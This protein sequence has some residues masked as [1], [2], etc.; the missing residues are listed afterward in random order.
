MRCTHGRCPHEVT[1]SE[2]SA[3]ALVPVLTWQQKHKQQSKTL[4][5]VQTFSPECLGTRLALLTLAHARV[6]CSWYVR[7]RARAC[8]CP[9]AC[10][11]VCV[12]ARALYLSS[13]PLTKCCLYH[14]LATS[15]FHKVAFSFPGSPPARDVD[16]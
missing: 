2:T 1:V 8:S 12:C 11:C 16:A 10:V 9:C 5:Y 15:L 14:D 13:S 4:H 6:F 7:A 3:V